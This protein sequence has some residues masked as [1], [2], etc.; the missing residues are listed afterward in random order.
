MIFSAGDSRRSPT[1]ALYDTPS[2]QRSREPRTG[3]RSSFSARSI[4]STQNSGMRWLTLPASS[5][6]SIERSNSRAF[7]AR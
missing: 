6:N 3:L 4:F 5:M 1:P 2:E 7:H